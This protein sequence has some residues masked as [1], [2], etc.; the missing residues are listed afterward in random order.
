MKRFQLPLLLLILL[1]MVGMILFINYRYEVDSH[2][3]LFKITQQM[4]VASILDSYQ[5][6]IE[7]IFEERFNAPQIISLIAQ[8]KHANE[9]QLAQIRG[10]LYR[11][12]YSTYENLH[13]KDIR[14][15]QFVLA[16]GKSFLRFNRPD[17]FGDSISN[18]RPLLNKVLKGEAQGGILENGR[19]Y[20]CYRYAFPLISDGEV[21][22]IVDFGISFDAI[23]HS[24]SRVNQ[25]TGSNYS[26]II[27]RDLLESI[28]HPSSRNLYRNSTISNNYLIEHQLYSHLSSEIDEI[29]SVLQNSQSIQQ[30]I[31]SGNSSATEICLKGSKCYSISLQPVMDSKQRTAGYIVNYTPMEDLNYLRQ[32]H[33]SAFLLGGLLLLIAGFALYRWLLS[34]QRLRT[35]S[36][37]MAEGMYVMDPSG[38]ILYVNPTACQLLKYSKQELLGQDAHVLLHRDST[39]HAFPHEACSIQRHTLNGIN[40]KSDEELFRCRDGKIIRASVVSSPL[41]SNGR[42]SGS[43]VLFR[44]I[45]AEYEVK[46]RLLRSDVAFSSL[47]E[48]VMVT[49]NKGRIQAVNRAF[50]VITGYSE[51]D[52][53]GKNP[54]ILKSGQHDDVFYQALWHQVIHTGGWEGEIWNR[55]KNGEIYPEFLR[56]TS[57]KDS[58]GE[59]T[60]YVATFSDI[61]EKRQHE[62]QLRKLAY[63]DTLTNL[64]NR[65]AF[66]EMFERA[67]AHSQ[68]RETRCAL[69]YLDLDRFKKINDTL[70]HVVGDEV[71]VEAAARLQQAV[72]SEDEVARLGGDE[73]IVMLED[74]PDNDAPARVARK[75]LSLLM[76]PIMSEPHMLHITASIGIAIFPEDGRDATTLLKNADAAMYMAK[77]VGRNNFHYFTPA[78]AEKEEDRFKLEIDLHTALLND[79]FMLYYQP[80]IDLHSGE[81]TGI[82]ALLRWQHPQRGL[83]KAGEFLSVAHDAGVMRDITNWVITESCTQL[84]AW[85]DA[86]LQPG[87]VAINIDA[88]TFNSSDAYDQ[89]GRTVQITGISPHLVELEIPESG[90]LEKAFDDVFWRQMVDLGFILTIDD[91]GTGE[92]SLFRLKHLPVNMLKIDKSFIR[93]IESD[94]DD[95]AI[96]HTVIAMGKSLGL[97]VLA[98][99]VENHQQLCFLQEMGC[100]Q[101]QGHLISEPQ[102]AQV[103]SEFLTNKP[104][105]TQLDIKVTERC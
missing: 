48:G 97:M 87:R 38:S 9:T 5:Q 55:R 100:D 73:F 11:R 54:R 70:G 41:W 88:H 29:D 39:G 76:Q 74:I 59:I 104:Y 89:I 98:E 27:N 35:I 10:K 14:T 80:K 95:R 23:R 34:N 22:G 84:Q 2:Q 8:T 92:S 51:K 25:V 16:N 36:D 20:P 50:S 93:D 57:V 26:F 7:V 102:P 44:D 77:H 83:L 45:N 31:D 19:I 66:L 103:I 105:K 43:V 71:L 72:R 15:L 33:L 96:I 85:L 40:Y 69:L 61:T 99:G 82:E 46:Q 91:F 68:R 78:M 53:L 62:Q 81:I 32:S 101:V 47:A 86:G 13:N 18:D 3:Q 4:A 21:V 12:F 24:L 17:L 6:M 67:L 64:H 37:H 30:A 58:S 28:S 94:A 60:E 42:L 75:I 63:N 1:C 79:E 65:T 49:D 52:V 56:I 90:L